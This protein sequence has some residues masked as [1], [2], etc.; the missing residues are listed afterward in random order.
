MRLYFPILLLIAAFCAGCT[1]TQESR[2]RDKAT[3]LLVTDYRNR[4]Q[5]RINELNQNSTRL[6]NT[7]I[8]ELNA[9]GTVQFNQQLQLQAQQVA[10]QI[11]T[12]WQQQTLPGTF[13]NT[14]YSSLQTDYL[15]LNNIETNIT[16]AQQAYKTSYQALSLDLAAL[17]AIQSSLQNLSIKRQA[18]QQKLTAFLEE[19]YKAYSAVQQAQSQSSQQSSGSK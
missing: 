2:D 12:S 18:N 11:L 14:C 3:A 17:D 15:S 7:E 6:F 13:A 10:E 19:L 9:L 5:N 4:Q 8:N 1:T 16:S